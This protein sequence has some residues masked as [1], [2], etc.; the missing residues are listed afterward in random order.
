MWPSPAGE[1]S[2]TF[3][4]MRAIVS[5]ALTKHGDAVGALP[6]DHAFAVEPAPAIVSLS[7]ERSLSDIPLFQ[8]SKDARVPGRKVRPLAPP[9]AA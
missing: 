6:V 3:L 7:A 5:P 8:P 2:N 4:P 1:V 9:K